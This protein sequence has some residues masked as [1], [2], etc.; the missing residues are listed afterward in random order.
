LK[1]KFA[2]DA[3]VLFGVASYCVWLASD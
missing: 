2:D 3:A 1:N